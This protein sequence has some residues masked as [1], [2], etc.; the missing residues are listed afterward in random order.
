MG[1]EAN[2]I[3]HRELSFMEQSHGHMLK[4]DINGKRTTDESCAKE[5]LYKQRSKVKKSLH[6]QQMSSEKKLREN[7]PEKKR[8]CKAALSGT[9]VGEVYM[10]RCKQQNAQTNSG[11]NSRRQQDILSQC[12]KQ[13][14]K[15][16]Q[17]VN[18][19]RKQMP[20][21]F[22]DKKREKQGTTSQ[23]KKGYSDMVSPP[24]Q[25]TGKCLKR[26][27]RM[28]QRVGQEEPQ[29]LPLILPKLHLVLTR[30]EIHED[31]IK[32][33]GHKYTGKPKK[34]TLV[35]KGL[36]LCTTLTRPSSIGY[37]NEP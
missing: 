11:F 21:S 36:G 7:E 3:M 17:P 10:R 28:P 13:T 26:S 23:K 27:C 31:W 25:L 22:S 18:R 2:L 12:K 33:T 16:E 32:I 9:A 1:E 20:R 5:S 6:H 37:L 4:R 29:P 30:K 35:Q 14:A 8:T 19:R 34:S 24:D 15:L